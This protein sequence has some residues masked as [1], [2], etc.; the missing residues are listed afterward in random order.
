M[1]ESDSQ[2][3]KDEHAQAHVD[4]T[5]TL[6]QLKSMLAELPEVMDDY[7]VF[8]AGDPEGNDFHGF[9]QLTVGWADTTYRPDRISG[10]YPDEGK[11]GSWLEAMES[12]TRS[13]IEGDEEDYHDEE[14]DEPAEDEP[15][16]PG[17]NV[18][19]VTLWP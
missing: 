16:D 12:A 1:T 4:G 14:E 2:V 11:N 3:L 18:R 8:V 17:E 6:G 10:Y 7:I 9:S 5:V 15:F 19:A 13:L